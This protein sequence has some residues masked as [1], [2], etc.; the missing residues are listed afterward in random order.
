MAEHVP[1]VFCVP[2]FRAFIR[3]QSVGQEGQR[4]GGHLPGVHLL[5]GSGGGVARV[6]E[7]GEPV[8]VPFFIQ[9]GKGFIGHED[10]PAHFQHGG[11]P[12]GRVRGTLR[13]VRTLAVTSS[14]TSPSPRVA[15]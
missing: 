10:F 5:E 9:F 15:A 2:E 3:A 1:E 14:P 11:A 8:G 7:C 4:P 6:G 12:G 13:M